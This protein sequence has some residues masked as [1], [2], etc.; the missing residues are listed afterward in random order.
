[1][2]SCIFCKVVKGEAPSWKVFENE[3][4]YAFL[5]INPATRYHTLV[6]PKKHATNILDVDSEDL[7]AVMTVV[8]QLTQ[9]YRDELG[10][11]DIQIITNAGAVAQQTVFH[12]HVHIVPRTIGDGQDI[13]WR[14]H[15]EWR[16][17]LDAML[18]KLS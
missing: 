9:K 18:K 1:M 11:Q 4:V 2:E 10:F 15:P 12:W 17:E 6:V 8:Q 14:T 13:Y 16:G 5:D 3:R 7:Q